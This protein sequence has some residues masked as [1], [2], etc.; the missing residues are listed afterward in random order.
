MTSEP[1]AAPAAGVSLD[2]EQE[3]VCAL[4]PSGHARVLGA[5]GSGKTTALIEA[6]GRLIETGALAPRELLVV[7]ANRRVSAE[8]RTRL[9]RRVSGPLGGTMVR[10]PSSLAFQVVAAQ[11]A[12]LARPRPRLL[13]GAAQDEL[14]AELVEELGR[15][16]GL[17]LPAEVLRSVQFRN[18]LRELRR[19]TVDAGLDPAA[20]PGLAARTPDAAEWAPAWAD[21]AALLDALDA[22]VAQR[23]P[24]EYGTSEL[25][26]AA[27]AAIRDEDPLGGAPEPPRLILLDDAQ[28]LSAS[29][30][31][32]LAALADRGTAIWAFGDPDIATSAFQGPAVGLLSGIG[33]ALRGH[34]GRAEAPGRAG[35]PESEILLGT[36]H[37][38]GATLRARVADITARIGAAELGAQRATPASAARPEGRL[39]FSLASSPSE[40]LGIIAH[41]IRERH[42]GL[43]PAGEPGGP[44]SELAWSEIAVICRSQADAARVSRSLAIQQVPTGQAS[45]GIVLREHG[46]VRELILVVQLALGLRA[47]DTPAIEALL[48]GALGGLDRLAVK[49]LRAALSLQER[50]SGGERTLAEILDEAVRHPEFGVAVDSRGGRALRRI[51]SVFAAAEAVARNGGSPREVLWAAWSGSGLADRW[52]RDALEGEGAVSDDANRL[53]DAVVALFFAVQRH[54][55]QGS[56]EPIAEFLD[57]LLRSELPEDSLARQ[58]EREAI[59]V[60]T[61]Q[62]MIGREARFVV[63]I[64]LQEGVWP[65]VKPRG[66]VLG[67]AALERLLRTGE[68][69]TPSRRDTVHDELRLLAQAVSRARDGVLAVSLATDDEQPSSFTDAWLPDAVTG[70]PSTRLTLR[71]TVAELRRRVTADPGDTAALDALVELAVAGV[72]GADP[73]QWYGVE[74]LSSAEPL[75]DLSDPEARVPVS[76]SQVERVET[77]PLDWAIATLGGGGGNAAADVGTLVHHAFETVTRAD[78]AALNAV[79]DE[80]WGLLDFE[81]GWE[82]E[83]MR[84][85]A[86]KMVRGLVD[87][88]DEFDGSRR[89]LVGSERGFRIALGQAE[90]RGLID[91]LEAVPTADGGE[92]LSVVDLKTGK[93]PP[94]QKQVT[95]HAQLAAYQLAIVLNAIELGEEG[96]ASPEEPSAGTEPEPGAAPGNGGARLLYVHPGA[97]GAGRTFREFGQSALPEEAQRAFIERVQRAAETM[98]GAEFTARVEHH[99]SSRFSFGQCRIHVIRPVSQA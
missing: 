8:L 19:V 43:G 70:L 76:P 5:P 55:E 63:L 45:G 78:E 49:R 66:S 88:L 7:A 90:L 27:I 35:T 22:R 9:E 56:E 21:A 69:S 25:I 81:A 75:V 82:S 77:C 3:A 17:R 85:V 84:G 42:L 4:S 71:G 58:S 16:G 11:R 73:G 40:Q 94:S 51:G 61:P 52:E 38:H 64:G 92:E 97:V 83:R 46:V 50:R 62:G 57:S 20:L 30:A 93:T 1:D 2:A 60:A 26:R 24:D 53:L 96:A 95:E 33:R 67:S 44:G 98:A 32:L 10:T 29:A 87:Y 47:L 13:T 68:A 34:G 80:S 79:L 37:R 6:V 36:V 65:N 15:Q 41:R 59:T 28:E 99:C 86:S 48:S 39:E 14:I 54:E 31:G 18:E 12:A 72:A 89:S 23:H 91:R 74:P